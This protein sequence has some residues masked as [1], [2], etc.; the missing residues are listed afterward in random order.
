MKKSVAIVHLYTFFCV[1]FGFSQERISVLD[2]GLSFQR[3]ENVLLHSEMPKMTQSGEKKYTDGKVV[4]GIVIEDEA[5]L[6]KQY[7]IFEYNISIALKKLLLQKSDLIR[8]DYLSLLNTDTFVL[9]QGRLSSVEE[10]YKLLYC[11]NRPIGEMC[12]YAQLYEGSYVAPDLYGLY[13]VVVVDKYLVHISLRLTDANYSL[14]P[15]LPQYFYYNSEFD[16]YWWKD[17][18]IEPRAKLFQQLLS[19]DYRELPDALQLLRE[20]W[21]TVFNTLEIPEYREEDSTDNQ[22]QARVELRSFEPTVAL[23]SDGEIPNNSVDDLTN[24]TEY[25]TE[26]IDN[27][28]PAVYITSLF[29]VI[30]VGC[31]I[32][33]IA[34][35]LFIRQKK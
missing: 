12:G 26:D 14:P 23:V 9:S 10:I 30:L 28:R 3:P 20:S 22:T 31:V 34:V 35:L 15:V 33:L 21:D 19:A 2:G 32:V 5:D 8:E 17:R 13:F 29:W 7:E 11:Q 25:A 24:S 6:R 1:M 4:L 18:L 16:E 27:Y